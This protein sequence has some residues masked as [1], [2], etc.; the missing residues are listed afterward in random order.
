[1][2]SDEVAGLGREVKAL[3]DQRRYEETLSSA[4]HFASAAPQ[5]ARAWLAVGLAQQG[6]GHLLEALQAADKAVSL[7]ATLAAPWQMQGVI[8]VK[9]QRFA[10]AAQAL[11]QAL[12]RA[13]SEGSVWAMLGFALQHQF[14]ND[15]ALAAY[16]QAWQLHY[17]TAEVLYGQISTLSALGRYADALSRAE[18]YVLRFPEDVSA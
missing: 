12:E 3:L 10:E 13:P 6:L 15:E 2:S 11:R 16:D 9:L 7:D 5:S 8:L 4:E 14:L 17:Q 1:V 18:E